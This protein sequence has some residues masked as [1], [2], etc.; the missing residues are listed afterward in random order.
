[1]PDLC[2]RN[3]Q[4]KASKDKNRTR[5]QA[6]IKMGKLSNEYRKILCMSNKIKRYR[7]IDLERRVTQTLDLL[8]FILVP[9]L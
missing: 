3:K 4:T 9:S 8:F 7:N 1:M 5:W 6:K 2:V